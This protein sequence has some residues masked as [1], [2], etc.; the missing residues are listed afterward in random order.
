[1]IAGLRLALADIETRPPRRAEPLAERPK[2]RRDNKGR[3]P[4]VVE[5]F[6]NA[7]PERKAERARN[8]ITARM[9]KR[10]ERLRAAAEAEAAENSPPPSPA[11]APEPTPE[12]AAPPPVPA[13]VDEPC[14][15]KPAPPPP[16]P[17]GGF[18]DA[19]ADRARQL[20]RAQW[21][22]DATV[23]ATGV[24]PRKVRRLAE[25]ISAQHLAKDAGTGAAA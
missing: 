6:K 14:R 17:F 21:G 24:P 16:P 12:P 3:P 7:T 15:P 8:A 25:E 18:D 19:Q 1:M 20:L 5:W 22:V 13:P 2:P 10:E 4:A 23:T 9:V 11:P